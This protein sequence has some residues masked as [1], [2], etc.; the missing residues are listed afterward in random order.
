M[1]AS[2]TSNSTVCVS[3][4]FFSDPFNTFLVMLRILITVLYIGWFLLALKFKDFHTRKMS[5]IYNLNIIGLFNCIIAVFFLLSD[6]CAVLSKDVCVFQSFTSIFSAN[7][8]G[9]GL[10]AL[11]LYRLSCFYVTSL[12]NNISIKWLVV[13]ISLSWILPILFTSIQLFV[14]DTNFYFSYLIF[15]CFM[16]SKSMPSF[17]FFTITNTVLPNMVII[18]AYIWWSLRMRRLQS[19]IR[20]KGSSPRITIQLIFYIIMFELNCIS[21]IIIFYQTILMRPLVSF[22]VLQ[23][24]RVFRWLHHFS[25]LALLYFTTALMNRL[26]KC[27]LRKA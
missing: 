19:T 16:E 25:P 26:K 21:N 23:Y 11:A 2:N 5:Y 22:Q 17:I 6:N 9:Y 8:S 4:S 1:N 27:F 24:L 10:A 3:Q 7:L 14:F 20:S 13:G 15:V 12:K 18:I